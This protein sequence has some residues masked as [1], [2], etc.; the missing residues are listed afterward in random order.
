MIQYNLTLFSSSAN[1]EHSSILNIENTSNEH[2][3]LHIHLGTLSIRTTTTA[4]LKLFEYTTAKLSSPKTI[5]K[6]HKKQEISS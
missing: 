5:T 6:E 3:P 2:Q 4:L 1:T